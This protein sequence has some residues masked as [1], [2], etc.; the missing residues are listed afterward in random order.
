MDERALI[1]SAQKGDLNAFNQLVLAYQELVY[2]VAYRILGNEDK[3]MDATQDAFLKGFRAL[4]RFRGGSFKT[5]I[6]RI[7]TNCAY[8]Q[9]RTMRRR[10]T[11]PLDDLVENEEHSRIFEDPQEAP[12]DYI[13]RQE[14]NA[15]IQLGLQSL[16]YE[17]RVV[18]VM[19]D[20]QGMSYEEIASATSIS[21]GTV[22]S[23]LSRGRAKLRNFLLAHEELLP[24]KYRLG[25][26]KR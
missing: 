22:K 25:N 18:L 20:I 9:L 1:A 4:P 8:D 21:L 24:S 2:N 26:D 14:L 5:W 11:T 6:L 16:P 7:V 3:A 23:R 12:D 19:S 17:Q 13:E 10:P 15:L